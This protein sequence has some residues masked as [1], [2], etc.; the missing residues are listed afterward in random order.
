MLCNQK[1]Y[2]THILIKPSLHNI[3]LQFDSLFLHF[4]VYSLPLCPAS[5]GFLWKMVSCLSGL[6]RFVGLS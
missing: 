2:H 5:E 3:F 4:N 1:A 6:S